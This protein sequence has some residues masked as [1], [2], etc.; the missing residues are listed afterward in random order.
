MNK[1]MNKMKII[2]WGIML[3]IGF[4]LTGTFIGVAMN[5]ENMVSIMK[6]GNNITD[7]QSPEFPLFPNR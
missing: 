5:A 7:E 4:M 3:L 2:F 6:E 1:I